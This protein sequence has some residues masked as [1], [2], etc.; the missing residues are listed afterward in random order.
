MAFEHLFMDNTQGYPQE[1][2]ITLFP[3]SVIKTDKNT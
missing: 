3:L 2:W 1:W